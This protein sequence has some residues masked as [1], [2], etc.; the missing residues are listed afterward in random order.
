MC[1]CVDVGIQGFVLSSYVANVCH[2]PRGMCLCCRE[3]RGFADKSR[4]CT[5]ITRTR[6]VGIG[7]WVSDFGADTRLGKVWIWNS[8]VRRECNAYNMDDCGDRSISYPNE[9]YFSC[10]NGVPELLGDQI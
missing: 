1:V 4:A 2:S 10:Y 8:K 6:C 7:I 5:N 3:I 9:S